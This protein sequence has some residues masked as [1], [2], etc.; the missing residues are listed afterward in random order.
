MV[1]TA[2]ALVLGGFTWVVLEY[3]LHRFVGHAPRS[4]T[5][6]ANEHR[7]HHAEGNY[8]APTSKKVLAVTPAVA[9]VA[10]AGG[11]ALGAPGAVYAV[12]LGLTYMGYEWFHRRL[13]THPP[14]GRFG[15][16][17][18]R[19]HFHHHFGDPKSNH[20]VTSPLMDWMVGTS[21]EP[22]VIRVPIKLAPYWLVDPATTTVFS[23][24]TTDYTLSGLRAAPTGNSDT[25]LPAGEPLG[26]PPGR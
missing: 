10:T 15:R 23:Q 22:G 26:V 5:E 14:V 6:F 18:R 20:G 25:Q 19:H 16:W 12:G 17:A 13:H 8:F 4:R 7:R 9:L 21:R 3:V 24:Y 1:G 11:Y 2:V